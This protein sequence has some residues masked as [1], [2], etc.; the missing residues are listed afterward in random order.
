MFPLIPLPFYM[1]F[2]GDTRNRSSSCTMASQQGF[3]MISFQEEV[4][5]FRSGTGTLRT[6]QLFYPIYWT[7]SRRISRVQPR[8]CASP[9]G[10]KIWTLLFAFRFMFGRVWVF[11]HFADFRGWSVFSPQ[12]RNTCSEF[13]VPLLQH[14]RSFKNLRR[15]ASSMNATM[16]CCKRFLVVI[17]H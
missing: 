11:M 5:N 16:K 1:A 13:A 17:I 7:G 6:L 14:F 3:S 2:A 10:K 12:L 4:V 8:K 15:L 9:G